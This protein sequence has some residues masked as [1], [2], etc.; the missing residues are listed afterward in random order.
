MNSLKL[1]VPSL[2]SHNNARNLAAKSSNY[3]SAATVCDVDREAIIRFIAVKVMGFKNV[4]E[5]VLGEHGGG[6]EPLFIQPLKF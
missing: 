5:V 1:E 6:H 2:A 3:D 4:C